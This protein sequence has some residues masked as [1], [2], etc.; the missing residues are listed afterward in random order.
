V[1]VPENVGPDVDRFTRNPLD[2][3]AAT[4][5]PWKYILDV[6]GAAARD[7]SILRRSP[8]ERQNRHPFPQGV[9]VM[10]C[11][12]NGQTNRWFHEEQT[13]GRRDCTL[14]QGLT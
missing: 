13:T 1:T 4:I 2:G 11:L 9:T 10:E 14:Q 7:K 5:H 8:D 3:V 6:K 12:A